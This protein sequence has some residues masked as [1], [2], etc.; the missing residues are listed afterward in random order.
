MT[1]ASIA[2]AVALVGLVGVW[3]GRLM[4]RSNEAMKWRRD[5]CLEAYADVVATCHVVFI[6]ANKTWVMDDPTTPKAIAQH[7]ILISKVTE[8]D[9]AGDKASLIGSPE[10]NATI[11]RLTDHYREKIARQAIAP[12][13]STDEWNNIVRDGGGLYGSFVQQARKDLGL[14]PKQATTKD[15]I[16]RFDDRLM[17]LHPTGDT[18]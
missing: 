5:R 4:E 18:P 3:V 15:Q 13:P 8:M 11:R 10:M 6:E 1:Q 14:I 12:K 7:D 16:L 9:R 2:I 17:S